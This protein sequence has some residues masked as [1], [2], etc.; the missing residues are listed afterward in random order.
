MSSALRCENLAKA[1]TLGEK[2]DIFTLTDFLAQ[3]TKA[4][5]GKGSPPPEKSDRSFWALKDLSFEL[6]EGKALGIVGRN[7][8][9]KSTLLKL[10][11]RITP[12]TRGSFSYRG[13]MASLLE[14]G[15]G[16]KQELTGLDN[17]FLSGTIL[18]LTQREI[19]QKLEEI[20]AFAE[21]EEFI[22]TPVKRYSSGMYVRLAFAVAAHLEPDILLL[23]EVLAVGDQRFQRKCLQK[24]RSVAGEGHTVLFVSHNMQAVAQLCDEAI[25]LDRGDMILHGDVY[26]VVQA[27]HEHNREVSQNEGLRVFDPPLGDRDAYIHSI[28]LG[29]P[30][31]PTCDFDIMSPISLEVEVVANSDLEDLQL[32]MTVLTLES[33]PIFTSTEPDTVNV[34]KGP[35]SYTFHIPTSKGRHR[36]STTLPCPFL[37]TGYYEIR[38]T[39]LGPHR[40]VVD[41]VK[42][43]QFEVHDHRGSFSSCLNHHR[44]SGDVVVALP[45]QRRSVDQ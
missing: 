9:G 35:E 41:Q 5:M 10:L 21:L 28:R 39:L 38:T 24:M 33:T 23:D 2:S 31:K 15:T 45:W 17:I 27:Y 19:R 4:W 44:A 16:F 43:F 18:G 37:N 26:Q 36:I 6:E 25:L 20:I 30:D 42:D 3:K 11:S 29:P 14:V 12:P 1:Y 8:S 7:G 32:T 34:S 22:D 40:V 13:R